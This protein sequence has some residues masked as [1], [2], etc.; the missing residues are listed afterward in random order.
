MANQG[1]SLL[2]QACILA[3]SAAGIATALSVTGEQLSQLG[4]NT[5]PA[6]TKPFASF[7][8]FYPFYLKEHSDVMCRR[9]H[10]VG[11]TLLVLLALFDTRIL[12]GAAAA[13][14]GGL[15]SFRA[16]ISV[17]HG[18]FEFCIALTC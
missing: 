18:F 1:T 5:E 9:S 13:V 14:A 3:I 17:P 6:G 16:L 10:F 2:T 15:W 7:E 12:V 4:I 8:Q 11:T